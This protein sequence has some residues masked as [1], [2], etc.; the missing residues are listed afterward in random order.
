MLEVVSINAA[1]ITKLRVK[2]QKKCRPTSEALSRWSIRAVVNSEN[3][4]YNVDY[5][6]SALTF[7]CDY[8]V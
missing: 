3:F 1:R 8:T 7:V 2:R 4:L 6:A 5:V